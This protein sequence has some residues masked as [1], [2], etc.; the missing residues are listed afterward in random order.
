MGINLEP[1]Y[2]IAKME[3]FLHH[4]QQQG[5]VVAV[6]RTRSFNRY[7]KQPGPVQV[8]YNGLHHTT[9]MK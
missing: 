8:I 3:D 6:F 1:K 4:W 9:V 7:R 2:W 5:Q